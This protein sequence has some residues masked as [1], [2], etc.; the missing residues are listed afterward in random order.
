M[1]VSKV[2]ATSLSTANKLGYIVNESLPLLN[3]GSLVRTVDQTIDRILGMYCVAA[4]AYGFDRKVAKQ[5]LGANALNESLTSSERQFLETGKG[6]TQDF[7]LQIEGI[8]ALCWSCRISA[9]EFSFA[10]KCPQ[11]FVTRLP[12]IKKGQNAQ[13][14]RAR[15]LLVSVEDIVQMADTAYCIHWAIRDNAI[16]GNKQIGNLPEYVVR[17][18]RIALDWL[19]EDEEWDSISVDT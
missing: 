15:A 3:V 14:L 12:D 19:L 6:A 16:R 10:T 2:R 9:N 13:Q 5:W 11:D 7:K 1:E 8:W 17:E 18:R 4:T